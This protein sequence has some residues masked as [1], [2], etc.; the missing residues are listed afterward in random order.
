MTL[1][2]QGR[3]ALNGLTPAVTE[4]GWV[5]EDAGE[6]IG[7][8]GGRIDVALVWGRGEDLGELQVPVEEAVGRQRTGNLCSDVRVDAV[9]NGREVSQSPV[10][11]GRGARPLVLDEGGAP[12]VR[13]VNLL[14]QLD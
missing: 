14:T 1:K 3:R 9:R 2:D 12:G 10:G 4:P 8:A 7:P 11:D 5:A 6:A 13:D